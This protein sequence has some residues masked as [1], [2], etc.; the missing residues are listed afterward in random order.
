MIASQVRRITTEQQLIIITLLNVKLLL[1]KNYDLDY[2][3]IFKS[4]RPRDA[5]QTAREATYFIYGSFSYSMHTVGLPYSL[6][7]FS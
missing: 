6:Y 2:N 5:A 7:S 1:A 4:C 3:F